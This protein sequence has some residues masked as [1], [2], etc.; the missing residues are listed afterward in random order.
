MIAQGTR[1]MGRG[2]QKIIVLNEVL[3]HADYAYI[4]SEVT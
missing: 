3:C 4:H 1:Q 2:D